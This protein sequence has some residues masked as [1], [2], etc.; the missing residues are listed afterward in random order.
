[1]AEILDVANELLPWSRLSSCQPGAA[2]RLVSP[3]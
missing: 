2:V 1:M 3:S